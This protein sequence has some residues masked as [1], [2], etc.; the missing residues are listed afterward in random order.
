VRVRAYNAAGATDY[1]WLTASGLNSWAVS[2]GPPVGAATFTAVG[3]T[4]MTVNWSSG[5][6]AGGYN[7]PG[8]PYLAQ[9]SASASFS[10]L[11]ASSQTYNQS[12]AFSGL[13][14]GV[15]YYARVEALSGDG[16]SSAFESLGSQL[17]TTLGAVT[18][19][20]AVRLSGAAFP[21][22]ALSWTAASGPLGS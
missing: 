4:G 8:T 3:A 5:T 10:P 19:L 7:S 16:N 11:T 1:S 13:S 18:N 12:A 21:S 6:A 22:L 17:T 9:I 14:P 2:P 15:A 20:S